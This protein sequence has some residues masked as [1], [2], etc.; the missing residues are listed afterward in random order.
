MFK[1]KLLQLLSI[2]D[3]VHSNGVVHR[4]IKPANILINQQSLKVKVID[5]GCG[6]KKQVIWF[7]SLI[8]NK[9]NKSTI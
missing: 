6:A 8:I 7:S 9:L 4:D 3:V 2:L 1:I 5:F